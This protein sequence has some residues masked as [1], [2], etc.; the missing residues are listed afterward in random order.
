MATLAKLYRRPSDPVQPDHLSHI[1]SDTNYSYLHFTDGSKTIFG[2]T[3]KTYETE[4][5]ELIRINRSLLINSQQITAWKRKGV[6]TMYI[7]VGEKRYEV[8]RRRIDEVMDR[9]L[10]PV[11]E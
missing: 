10:S 1:T 8:A 2:R 6:N 7:T 5:P 11:T 9:L 4:Y 3:L